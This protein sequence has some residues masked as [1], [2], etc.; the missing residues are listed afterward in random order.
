MN[1]KIIKDV[2]S[3]GAGVLASAFFLNA[4]H[5]RHHGRTT[6]GDHSMRVA[7]TGLQI[8][9]LLEKFHVEVDEKAVIRS[10]LCHDLGILGRDEK[11]EN[12]RECC[13]RHPVES[14][15]V[16]NYILEDLTEKEA[17]SISNHMWPLAGKK[18][19]YIEGLILTVADK[20]SSVLDTVKP[21][22]RR[23]AAADGETA[24]RLIIDEMNRK[25]SSCL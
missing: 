19:R 13:W 12:N 10:A 4:M 20:Y 22:M 25:K 21:K 8:S 17:D 5:Q 9:R 1:E 2:C 14:V 16:A 18:P 3:V 23:K 15:D 24:H 11:F 6:V 7:C